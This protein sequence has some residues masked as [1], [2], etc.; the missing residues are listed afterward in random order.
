MLAMRNSSQMKNPCFSCPETGCGRQST[1]EKYL[2][3]YESNREEDRKRKAQA[4][5]SFYV[6]DEIEKAKRGSDRL[7][8][9]RRNT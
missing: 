2:T 6:S 3:F 1:C 5:L 4:T 8:K 7:K 9:Y